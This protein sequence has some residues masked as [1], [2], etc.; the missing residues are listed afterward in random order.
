MRETIQA[1]IERARGKITDVKIDIK[2]VVV[3]VVG[4][5][6]AL[7]T[8]NGIDRRE[9]SEYI[10]VIDFFEINLLE[11]ADGVWKIKK[12]YY[13]INFPLTFAETIEEKYRRDNSPVIDKLD[14][15]I[16]HLWSLI[17]NDIDYFKQAGTTP[18]EY[19]RM[20]GNRFAKTWNQKLGFD[21]LINGFV[22]SLQFM[23]SQVEVLERNETTFKAKF[24]ATDRNK[25]WDITSE[26]LLIVCQNNSRLYGKQ[27]HT[28]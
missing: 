27:L 4:P 12:H 24:L 5:N 6:S 22:W 3:D 23:S 2:Q 13:N 16:G 21:G 14:W 9:W 1:N 18:A 26:E 8:T 11:R 28:F 17:C 15:S 10:Q 19:G 20:F 25:G 7:V